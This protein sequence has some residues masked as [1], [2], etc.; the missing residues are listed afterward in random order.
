MQQKE[1]LQYVTALY[2]NMGYF[3]ISFSPSIQYM[4]T[5]A[6]KFGKF[7]YNH[8][9]IGMCYSGDTFHSKVDKIIV[10]FEVNKTLH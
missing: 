2:L 6:T 10:D 4:M 3:T 1:G 8:L 5:I 9:P 7:W